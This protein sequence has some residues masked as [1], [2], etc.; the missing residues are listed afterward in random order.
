MSLRS[1]LTRRLPNNAATPKQQPQWIDQV[2]RCGLSNAI[3]CSYAGEPVR[4]RVSYRH[5]SPGVRAALTFQIKNKGAGLR[6]QDP[7]VLFQPWQ[8]V[9]VGGCVC[10]G[11]LL[12]LCTTQ[13]DCVDL[14]GQCT[15]VCSPW[16]VQDTQDDTTK[17]R[18]M[19]LGLSI[20]RCAPQLGLGL[21]TSQSSLADY[22]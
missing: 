22:S 16:C 17:Y 13:H 15:H 18:G 7:S 20:T 9:C 8:Q 11:K 12:L 4:I 19:G 2:L 5:S 3:K 1:S 21:T 10:V 6:V 14:H